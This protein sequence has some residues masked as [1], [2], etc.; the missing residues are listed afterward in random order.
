MKSYDYDS[1]ITS[2][3]H[4]FANVYNDFAFNHLTSFIYIV[5]LVQLDF[6]VVELPHPA[7]GLLGPGTITPLVEVIEP[8][9]ENNIRKKRRKYKDHMG[10][11]PIYHSHQMQH[12]YFLLNYNTKCVKSVRNRP[13]GSINLP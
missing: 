5:R 7:L 6:Q 12:D 2:H 10:R 3:F 1:Y 8:A 13:L 4:G 11:S 9:P